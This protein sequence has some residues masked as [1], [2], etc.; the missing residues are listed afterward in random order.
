MNKFEKLQKKYAA[1]QGNSAGLQKKKE[2]LLEQKSRL[3]SECQ[4]AAENG[5]EVIIDFVGK[6]DDKAFKGGS[7]KDYR[8]VL[9][10]QSF[11]PGFE[12]GIVGHQS[13]DKFDLKLT[14]PKDYGVKE[15]AGA[16][17]VSTFISSWMR[18]SP[19][20]AVALI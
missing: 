10:S 15:L 20:R 8:L 1:A 7:A 4:K 12:D 5:D 2:E 17:T 19:S 16:K 9:G 18:F 14:F 6:K 3:E 13:G 11:I